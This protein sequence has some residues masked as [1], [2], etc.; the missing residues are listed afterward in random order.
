MFKLNQQM[1][2]CDLH[3]NNSRDPPSAFNSAPGKTFC[4][5]HLALTDIPAISL[6]PYIL[7]TS[8]KL[9]GYNHCIAFW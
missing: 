1:V 6:I 7:P 2:T 3:Q 9:K 4:Q 5:E 8:S